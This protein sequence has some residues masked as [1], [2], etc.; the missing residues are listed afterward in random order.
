M[1]DPQVR[2]LIETAINS[3]CKL[4]IAVLF[5]ER[6]S[7]RLSASE[8]A[9]RVFRDRWSVETALNELTDAEVLELRNGRYGLPAATGLREQVRRLQDGYAD[10]LT[11]MELLHFLREVERYQPYRHELPHRFWDSIAA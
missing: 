9:D 8:I 2:N 11:R 7:V 1:L 6:P 4:A 10:P 3:S 5:A